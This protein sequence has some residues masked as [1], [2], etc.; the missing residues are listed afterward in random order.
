MSCRLACW[1]LKRN[2][3]VN[4][5]SPAST[6]PRLLLRRPAEFDVQS[7]ALD[8]EFAAYHGLINQLASQYGGTPVGATGWDH[9][10]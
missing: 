3:S 2:G 5:W 4:R 1:P 6:R 7:S 8:Q 10:R 9:F